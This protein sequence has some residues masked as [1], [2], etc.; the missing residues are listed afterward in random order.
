MRLTFEAD[1]TYARA[2]LKRRGYPIA[3]FCGPNGTG[4]SAIMVYDTLPSLEAGRP[5]LS[6]V[7]LLDY[8]DPH[9]CGDRPWDRCDDLINHERERVDTVVDKLWSPEVF[10]DLPEVLLLSERDAEVAY[11]A[12]PDV[13]SQVP[14]GVM[15]RHRAAHRLYSKLTA[16]GQVVDWHDGDILLDEVTGIASSREFSSMPPQIANMLVQLRRRNVC[17]RWSSPAWG[18][19]DKII[20]EVSQSVTLTSAFLP[21][22]I[23]SVPGEP[24]RLWRE[25]RL[26]WA[27]TFDAQHFDEFDA[28]RADG[29]LKPVV[30]AMYWGPGAAMFGAY[31]TYD[32]VSALGSSDMASGACLTCGGRRRAVPC[33]CDDHKAPEAAMPRPRPALV[34]PRPVP[35]P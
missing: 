1:R 7:R 12:S 28:H 22:R 27:R 24:P 30:R 25:R 19:S 34:R 29:D 5:V 35:I 20:R 31:D 3:A 17:L 2:R 18:R 33:G 4:K 11:A 21:K 16:F 6:T 8:A 15:V 23:V 13:R 32:A 26:F 14:S 10:R 9:L